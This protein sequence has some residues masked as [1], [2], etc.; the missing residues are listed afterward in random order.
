M[1][2]TRTFLHRSAPRIASAA[3]KQ[4]QNAALCNR[5]FYTAVDTSSNT[6]LLPKR[7]SHPSTTI[8][9]ISLPQQ[10]VAPR[11]FSSAS[12]RGTVSDGNPT[13]C[14]TSQKTPGHVTRTLRVLD[15]DVVKKI[16][17]ELRS[18]DV[19]S[20]GRIDTEEL[21]QLLRGHNTAFTEEEIVEIGE[22]FYAGKSGGSVS[23]ER[24]VEA[25]DKIVQ[26]EGED[27]GI[28][29][30][31]ATGNPLD[32]G[33][34]GNEYLFFKSH[35][36]YT[37]EDL[38]G[39]KLV[40]TEPQNLSDRLALTCVKAVR[41]GFDKATGWDNGDITPNKVLHR[42]IYLET[43]AAV[44][45][46]VA[47]IVRHFRSLR[48]MER[49]GGMMQMFLDEANN[50]RMHLLTFVRMKNPGNLFRAAVIAGQ[51]GF[52]SAFLVSYIIAPKFC[53][54]FV[55]YIEEEA[56]TTYTKIIDAIEKAPEESE[57]AQWKTES[58]PSIARSYWKLGQNGTVLDVMYAVRADEAEHRDVNHLCSVLQEGVP[59]PV[60]NTEQKLNTMLLK[61][62]QDMMEKNPEK[63][64]KINQA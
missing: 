2:A 25:M 33:T 56:V 10:W 15:M 24:F 16:L 38:T 45:G 43:I 21:K 44:P 27:G 34:C 61:Y 62:V 5:A 54:R 46:M 29:R 39:V 32:L 64:L 7:E 14:E 63:P 19:N 49:D 1:I 48:A 37:K 50:E 58:A 3:F 57:L 53:H 35:S 36:N 22:L 52:G 59:N 30:K 12:I 4:P 17:A 41:F 9:T 47:A 31:D 28:H 13:S 40:H 23:F 18:V 8:K 20:D 11:V 26:L 6:D 42:A 60:S 55:G 51:F